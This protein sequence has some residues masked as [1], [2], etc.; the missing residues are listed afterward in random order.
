MSNY[1]SGYNTRYQSNREEDEKKSAMPIIIIGIVALAIM[2]ALSLYLILYRGMPKSGSD[3]TSATVGGNVVTVTPTDVISLSD[4]NTVGDLRFMA[5]NMFPGDRESKHVY[6]GIEDAGVQALCFDVRVTDQ[7]KSLADVM[8]I[9]VAV[10]GVT[11]YDGSVANLP[12]VMRVLLDETAQELDYEIALY[13]DTAV[14]NDYQQASLELAFDWWVNDSDYAAE[15]TPPTEEDTGDK[16]PTIT[17]DLE[18]DCVP[19]CI[20]IC[21][22]CPAVPYLIVLILA[23]LLII[24][25]LLAGKRREPAPKPVVRPPRVRPVEPVVKPEKPVVVKKS[26]PEE[27]GGGYVLATLFGLMS[28]GTS[29]AMSSAMKQ[30]HRI[31]APK[32]V[33]RPKKKRKS[34]KKKSMLSRLLK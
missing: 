27:A 26:K 16:K 17:I 9:F 33:K 18:N 25:F 19:W 4:K 24:I 34:S 22:W 15:P 13:L 10:D 6:I 8:G 31:K 11:V 20:G 29:V 7:T 3:S 30:S 1:Y 21:P 32:P 14:G 12:S 2:L 5:N 23:L 28:I